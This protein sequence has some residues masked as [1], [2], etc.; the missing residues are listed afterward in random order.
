M[1]CIRIGTRESRLAMVQAEWVQMQLV[2]AHADLQV[3]IVGMTTQGDQVLDKKLDKIGGKGLFIKELE[4][5]LL[6]GEV[7]LAV[8]SA[9]DLPAKLAEGLC[10]VAT[11]T[12]EDPRDALVCRTGLSWET[13]PYGAVI[14]TSSARRELQILALRPD[15]N[16]KLLRGNVL[17][18]LAKLDQGDFDAIVL[19]TAGLKRLGLAHRMTSSFR[20]QEMVPA[21]GQGIL[22]LEARSDFDSGLL[23]CIHDHSAFFS[24]QL[25]RSAM[26]ALDGD[27][28]TPLGIHAESHY[29]GVMVSGFYGK[30]GTMRRSSEVYPRAEPVELGQRF[31]AMLLQKGVKP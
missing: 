28:S 20:T 2:N 27:C 16:I 24:L 5:A 8:H 19:A 12:R 14:G 31:A 1:R 10:L 13:L 7:D 21:V 6:K 4:Y 3:E 29:S 23:A 11:S 26:I 9:K 25:E 17:T 30:D 18:R 22:A 15:L